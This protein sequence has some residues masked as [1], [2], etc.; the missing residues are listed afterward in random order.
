MA[1]FIELCD[2]CS[3]HRTKTNKQTKIP[4]QSEKCT[5]DVDVSTEPDANTLGTRLYEGTCTFKSQ[6]EESVTFFDTPHKG[7]VQDEK[8]NTS[9][10]HGAENL[11]EKQLDNIVDY[12]QA[13][14]TNTQL[15]K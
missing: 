15:V 12:I 4:K 10:S 8:E 14:Y 9:T 11:A 7:N 13:M 5:Q 1:K 3:I 2:I 6:A